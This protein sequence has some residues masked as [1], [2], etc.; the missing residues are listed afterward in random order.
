V[1]IGPKQHCPSGPRMPGGQTIGLAGGTASILPITIFGLL[2]Q[3]HTSACLAQEGGFP[4]IRLAQHDVHI[5]PQ[6]RH[7]QSPEP[8]PLPS[9]DQL[10]GLRG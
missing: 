5:G 8:S 4:G 9:P 3:G 10:F 2:C 6:H 1:S 7:D